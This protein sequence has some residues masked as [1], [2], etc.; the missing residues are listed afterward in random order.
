M[1]ERE[2]PTVA[3]LRP[4]GSTIFHEMTSL[5]VRTG[6]VNLGQG[7][8]DSDGPASMLEAARAAISGGLNQYPPGPGM[9][10]LREAIAD[11]RARFGV[12]YDPDGEVLVT[13]G[14]TEAIAATI[15]GLVEPGREV[16]LLEPYYDSY[17]AAV[18]M[19]GAERRTVALTF[20]G[21]RYGLDAAAVEAAV[22]E[23][24]AMIV[25]NSPHN[26]TGTV[27]TRADIEAIADIARRHDLLVL[28][29]EV[30]E[31]LIFD[32]AVHVPI[33]TLPGMAERTVTVSS[34]AKTFNATGWK[35]GWAC[36]TPPLIDAVRTAKQ[37]LTFV[38]GGPFQ[39]AV[40]HALTAERAWIGELRESLQRRRDLLAKGLDE[41]GLRPSVSNG[42]YFVCADI[43]GLTD[44]DA[45]DFCRM[46][47][48]R[49]GVAAVPVSALADDQQRYRSQVRFAFCKAEDVL[50]E[51][52][53]RLDPL[54]DGL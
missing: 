12:D 49:F 3:R 30:Y 37:Y 29:D 34:A 40:A 51:A 28:T 44:M 17:A 43:S 33:A 50:V 31:H 45:K 18:A 53:T 36:S 47:P 54:R 16:I 35:I 8:P 39:P 42:T 26:P 32:D 10:V 19:A 9:P 24:T 25:V 13:V 23:K 2:I 5:A 41:I 48:E 14:A 27:F 46:L 1:G 20:D 52:I 6:A 22:T 38:G 4:F 21:T 15:L 11:E 7:F